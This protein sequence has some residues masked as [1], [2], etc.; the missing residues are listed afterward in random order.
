V[1]CAELLLYGSNSVGQFFESRLSTDI[2]NEHRS[3]TKSNERKQFV[4]TKIMYYTTK[5]S[6]PLLVRGDM[7][8]SWQDESVHRKNTTC[9]LSSPKSFRRR[10]RKRKLRETP[11]R[12]LVNDTV[13]KVSRACETRTDT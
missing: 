9:V 3:E 13:Q 4:A 1:D 5:A 6:A 10:T 8:Q 12:K 11:R 2:T 7:S